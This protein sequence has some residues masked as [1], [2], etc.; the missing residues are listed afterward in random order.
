MVQNI[1]FSCIHGPGHKNI[2]PNEL[3]YIAANIVKG[4]CWVNKKAIN[5]EATPGRQM[6]LIDKCWLSLAGGCKRR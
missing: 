6:L 1:L 2:A 3:L 5:T 4:L